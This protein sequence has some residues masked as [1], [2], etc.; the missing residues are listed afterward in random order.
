LEYGGNKIIKGTTSSN[1][2]KFIEN[3]FE[4]IPGQALHAKTLGFKHPTNNNFLRF[5][6]ELPEQFNKLLIQ[7]RKYSSY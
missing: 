1:Y 2:T 6:S 4:L 7:W 5:E 3:C